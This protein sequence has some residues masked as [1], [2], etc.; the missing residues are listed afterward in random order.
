MPAQYQESVIEGGNHAGFGSY[1]AQSGDGTASIS[2]E[3]QWGRRFLIFWRFKN[4]LLR[5]SCKFRF[6]LQ[7]NGTPHEALPRCRRS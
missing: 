7:G 5:S 2:A 1:G 4:I 3:E 6:F